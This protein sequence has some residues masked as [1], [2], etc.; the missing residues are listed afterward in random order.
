M[1]YLI[2]CSFEVGG[3]PFRMAEILNRHGVKTFYISLEQGASGHDSTQ[4]H[5]GDR[6]EDWDLSYMFTKGLSASK[7]INLLNQ[8]RKEYDIFFC[9]ATGNKAYL[10]EHAGINYKYWSYGS[11]LDQQCFAPVWPAGYAFWK[12]IIGYPYF[13]FTTRREQ[14]KSVYCA[15]S[16]MIAPYQIETCKTISPDKGLFFLPHFIKILDY[17]AL[18]SK[19]EESRK[20]ICEKIQADYFFF[21]SSR[22][23]WAG[24]KKALSDNKGNDIIIHSFAKYLRLSNAH[25]VKLIL[26]EKGPDVDESKLL[27]RNLGIDKFIVWIDEIRREE[28]D[29]YYQGAAICFG[30]FGTPVITFTAIEPLSNAT[31]CISFFKEK[32][33]G[34]PFYKETPPIFNSNDPDKIANVMSQTV[35][36]RNNYDNLSHKAWLWAKNNCSEE[37]F[38][39]SFLEVFS[40]KEA[41]K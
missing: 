24:K 7:K 19:K 6:C 30:Q 9:F 33:S 34:I 23:F 1:N 38:V 11:D 13:I 3:L 2:F 16:M 39:E 8:I 37:R 14:R 40:D 10:L 21:S 5:Y 22:H 41:I 31:P 26:V 32:S 35:M 29:K 25:M 15:D 20:D 18:V 12:K 36:D 4:F 28:L 17:P 27:A